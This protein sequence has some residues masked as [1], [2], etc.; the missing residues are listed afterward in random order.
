MVQEP[1]SGPYCS[2]CGK[3]QRLLF[4]LFSCDFCDGDIT[5]FY[6]FIVITKI[7]FSL[8]KDRVLKKGAVVSLYR[9]EEQAKRSFSDRSNYCV[10]LVDLTF[11]K[12]IIIWST[13]GKHNV[14]VLK[15]NIK[16]EMIND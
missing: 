1:V 11:E 2:V 5:R 9:T 3:P 14:H 6:G 8:H 10:A 15:T 13:V 16:L 12:S 4:N 7:W